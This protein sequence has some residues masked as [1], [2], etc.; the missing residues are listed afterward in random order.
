MLL[1]MRRLQR[2]ISGRRFHL[3][4]VSTKHRMMKKSDT[5]TFIHN[6][7]YSMHMQ[8]VHEIRPKELQKL[9]NESGRYTGRG[10]DQPSALRSMKQAKYTAENDGHFG[11]AAKYYTHFTSPIRRYPDLQIHRIIKD[12]LRGR[13]NDAKRHHYQKILPEVAKRSSEMERRADEAE[14]ETIKLKKYRIYAG[15]YR[16]GI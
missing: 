4:T 5:C 8:G 15:T 3:Y 12:N 11:L 6:F 9:A 10:N 16:R 7:G 1:Q 14:R 13:M 2:I